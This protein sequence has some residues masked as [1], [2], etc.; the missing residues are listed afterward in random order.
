MAPSSVGHASK[1]KPNSP[2]TAPDQQSA[3]AVMRTTAANCAA[4][5]LVETDDHRI[6]GGC[7][8]SLFNRNTQLALRETRLPAVMSRN[9][10]WPRNDHRRIVFGSQP[11]PRRRARRSTCAAP[12]SIRGRPYLL[13]KPVQRFGRH[14]SNHDHLVVGDHP[15]HRTGGPE[16]RRRKTDAIIAGRLNIDRRP[17][18]VRRRR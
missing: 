8:I 6:P 1:K 3:A 5:R 11:R 2:A 14:F 16:P 18:P 9:R 17:W 7:V 12:R 10:S 13:C 15:T 4:K